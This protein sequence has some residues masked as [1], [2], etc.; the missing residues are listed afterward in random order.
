MF[1]VMLDN[2]APQREIH[3]FSAPLP[4]L[5]VASDGRLDEAM[6]PSYSALLY[7]PLNGEKFGLYSILPADLVFSLGS[8]LTI[9]VVESMPCAIAAC[10]STDSIRS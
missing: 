4:P 7:D 6:P 9:A 5:I 2:L 1:G 8:E 10:A 3:L